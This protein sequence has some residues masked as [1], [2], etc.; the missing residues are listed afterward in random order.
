MDWVAVGMLI[1]TFVLA[2]LT[3]VYVRLTRQ[4]A[5]AATD[6]CVVTYVAHDEGRPT[7]L[8]VVVKNIGRGVARDVQ[9]EISR[10]LPERVWGTSPEDARPPEVERMS[11]GPLIEGIPALAPGETRQITWGQYGGLSKALGDQPIDVISRFRSQD[12]GSHSVHSVLEV[13]SFAKTSAVDTDGARQAAR[14][15]KRIADT[16]RDMLGVVKSGTNLG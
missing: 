7:I 2:V 3:A 13:R 11:S 1:T 8:M 14:E 10:P 6:P 5:R 9:F 4:L 15:L 12:G 16:L